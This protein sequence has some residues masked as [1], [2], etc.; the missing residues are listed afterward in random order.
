MVP[1]DDD[2]GLPAP[3]DF[4]GET[5]H[6]VGLAGD[7]G[8]SHHLGREAIVLS[9][10]L[11]FVFALQVHDANVMG[12]QGGGDN[13]EA[14]GFSPEYLLDGGDTVFLFRDAATGVGRVDEQYVHGP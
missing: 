11:L 5:K 13:L 9:P 2:H 12:D 4:R 14:E 3:F 8:E 6:R 10:E 7:G 1:P